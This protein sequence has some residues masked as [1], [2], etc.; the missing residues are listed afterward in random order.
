LPHGIYGR[1]AIR[2]VAAALGL[3][4]GGLLAECETLL[5][6]I[7]DPIAALCRLHGMRPA[8]VHQ[9]RTAP[10]ATPRDHERPS[11]RLAAAAAL[12]ALA[13]VGL[14]L[15]IVIVTVTA[16][17]LPFAALGRAAAPAFAVT[18]AILWLCYVVLFGGIAGATPGERA[19]GVRR[20]QHDGRPA[21]LRGIALRALRC[22]C[23]DVW[24][25]ERFGKW[26]GEMLIADWRF[27][28]ADRSR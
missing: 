25:I 10:P 19:C 28:V 1:A 20:R 3:P 14:L 26:V 17:E 5:A 8:A 27:P 2:S 18:A 12:D 23:R 6:P 13:V 22:A 16:F 9:A 15:L 7:D 24:L 4:P 11:A 21:D